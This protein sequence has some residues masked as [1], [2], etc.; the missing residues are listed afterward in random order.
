MPSI[1]NNEPAGREASSAAV[2]PSGRTLRTVSI[3]VPR[4]SSDSG[5]ISEKIIRSRLIWP[6]PTELRSTISKT[7][8]RP[9]KSANVPTGGLQGLAVLAGCRAN[10]LA[11][12]AEVEASLARFAAA[13]NEKSDVSPLDA[14]GL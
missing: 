5:A 9:F 3:D 13:A 12:D 1:V 14:K 11:I 8:S 10:H 6:Q 2:K 7:A 4:V